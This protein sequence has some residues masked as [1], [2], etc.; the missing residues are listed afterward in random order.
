MSLCTGL[1]WALQCWPSAGTDLHSALQ[2]TATLLHLAAL[3]TAGPAL[4]K[5]WPALG[6]AFAN[7]SQNCSVHSC[8]VCMVVQYVR[9]HER[10]SV[11]DRCTTTSAARSHAMYVAS[12]SSASRSRRSSSGSS[13]PVARSSCTSSLA[14]WL[15]CSSSARTFSPADAEPARRAGEPVRAAGEEAAFCR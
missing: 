12:A 10:C 8:T 11:Y 13:P 14:A 7:S 9:T 2:V 5:T 6:T 3:D 1:H 15:A 4:D